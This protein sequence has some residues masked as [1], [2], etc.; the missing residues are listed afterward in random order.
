MVIWIK[1]NN[2]NIQTQLKTIPTGKKGFPGGKKSA[3]TKE[4]QPNKRG[5]KKK[6]KDKYSGDTDHIG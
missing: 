2:S 6:K 1:K 4:K 5:F 3:D